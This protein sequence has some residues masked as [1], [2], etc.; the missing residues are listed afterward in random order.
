M[1]Y[2]QGDSNYSAGDSNYAAGGLFGSLLKIG[3]GFITGGPLGAV[4]AAIPS[5]S[6][7]S[8][9][10]KGPAIAPVVPTPGLAGFGQRLIPGGK[11]GYEVQLP[12][13][14][15]GRRMNPLNVRAL[16]R[17]GRRVKGFLRIARRLGALPV[18]RGKGKRLYV[19]H[20]RKK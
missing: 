9:K 5:F 13:R 7:G 16:R 14:M 4:G 17:A 2:Y 20:R 6:G 15:G 3:K 11:T 8:S 19:A 1:G 18:N 10:P 12:G